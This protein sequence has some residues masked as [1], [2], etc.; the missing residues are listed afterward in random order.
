VVP[1]ELARA[2]LEAQCLHRLRLSSLPPRG[3]HRASGQIRIRFVPTILSA[4]CFACSGCAIDTERSSLGYGDYVAL[5]CDQLGQEAVR[6]MRQASDRSEHILQDD[7]QMREK[8]KQQLVLVKQASTAKSCHA[9]SIAK[10][11][12]TQTP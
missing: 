1:L 10:P 8:A 2:K 3:S 7:Q 9:T 6:L 4:L 5:S 12:E 11:P